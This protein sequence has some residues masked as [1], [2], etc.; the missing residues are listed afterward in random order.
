MDW[1][2]D[3]ESRDK[4]DIRHLEHEL[5]HCDEGTIYAEKD[6]ACEETVEPKLS[7]LEEGEN[8]D[9]VEESRKRRQAIL[10]KYNCKKL[11][12]QNQV[13]PQIEVPEKEEKASLPVDE[14][15]GHSSLTI[16]IVPELS[17]CKD[18]GTDVDGVDSIFSEGKSP[19]RNITSVSEKTQGAEG[20]DG[21]ALKGKGDGL[22]VKRSGPNDNWD[23]KDGHYKCDAKDVLGNRY[24]VIS[25]LGSGVSSTVVRVKDLKPGKHDP[26]EVAIKIIHSNA[27]L[28]KAGQL[29]LEILKRLA[30]ADPE[31]RWHCVR[32]LSSFKHRNHLCLV[33]ESLDM[34]LR[35]VIDFRLKTH[36]TGFKLTAVR[37]Y[38]KHLFIS[39]KHLKE[40]GVLHCDIK[41]DNVLV[42]KATNSLKVCDF[43]VSMFAGKNEIT[44]YLVSR[45][46]RAPEVIL[47][48]PYD[49]PVDIWSVGCCL[50]ELYSGKHLFPGRSNNDMLRLHMELKGP[51][52][53]KML[54]KGAFTH[55]HFDQN[56]NFV[57][58]E[59]DPFTKKAIKRVILDI[60][61][62]Y[63]RSRI[64]G[65]RGEDP[66]MLTNFKDL[67]DKL[68][69]LDPNKRMTVAQALAHPFISTN[70]TKT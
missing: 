60:K 15:L 21:G 53:R 19:V 67:L 12:V 11:E 37:A 51:F 42:N 69:V 58:I 57:S 20:V 14:V 55:Q 30:A 4:K 29:E 46:Y 1:N 39:L 8:I 33:L 34:S 2:R 45:F 10:E 35:K 41:P 26:K 61:P 54:R 5:E 48:L 65:S 59:E 22:Q 16:S 27:I 25:V 66:K 23:N 49:H 13:E 3:M 47:G 38:A 68:F 17:D 64:T 52:P 31:D 50:Y 43:G 32:L 6:V 63:I 24:E 44:P 28:S 36:S 56:H 70:C 7:E 62:K 9:R 18:V 40:C